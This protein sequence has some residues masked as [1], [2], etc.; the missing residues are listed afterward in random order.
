[1]TFID[2]PSP[3][4][5]E[6]ALPI[7]TLVLHYTGMETAQ[8]AIE[9]LRCPI[10][11]VSAHYVVDENG[12]VYCLVDE[13]KRAWHAGVSSWNGQS[14]LNSASI[15]IEIVNGGHDFGLPEFPNAQI[16]QVMNLS[17]AILERY[18]INPFHVVGH[19]DIAP[20]RKQDPGEKFP[21]QTLAHH[22]VGV[23]PKINTSNGPG[24]I[25]TRPLFAIGQTGEG[26]KIL[27]T[28]L[29][30]LGYGLAQSGHFD[31]QTELV[32]CAFQR[33]YRPTKIDGI[34]DTQTLELLTELLR[35]KKKFA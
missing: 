33:R 7:S 13:E 15:G 17:R 9:R 28:G 34:V 8:L 19:S 21:W 16:E 24:S 5:D 25:D 31:E 30:Q 3:N 27:Q 11:K 20:N 18:K 12:Q 6:R 1:M 22:G 35:L 4:F 29:S 23:F 32:I 2:L 26:V 14:D 10:A